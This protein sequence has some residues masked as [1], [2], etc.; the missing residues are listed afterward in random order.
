[1]LGMGQET[2]T[3]PAAPSFGNMRIVSVVEFGLTFFVVLGALSF[4]KEVLALSYR[5]PPEVFVSPHE[6]DRCS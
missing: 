2:A 5:R 4:V 1:M 6:D 3:K